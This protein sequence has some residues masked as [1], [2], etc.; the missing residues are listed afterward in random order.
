MFRKIAQTCLA[1][2]NQ[3]YAGQ[4]KDDKAT[5]LKE[6]R[7]ATKTNYEEEILISPAYD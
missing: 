1:C 5:C 7:I 3:E 4:A 6:I 2:V